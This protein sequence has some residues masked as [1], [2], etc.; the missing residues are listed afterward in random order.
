MKKRLKYCIP[1]MAAAMVMTAAAPGVM[2]AEDTHLNAAMFMWMDGLDPAK[3]WNGWTTMRCGIGET[4]LTANENM[5]VVPCLADSWEQVDDTTYKF[6]IRQGVKFSNGNDMT[7][8]TVKASIERTAEQNSRGSNLKLASIEV[9]GE[10]VIFKTTEPYSAFPYYLTEPMCIIVDTT[11]DTSNYDNQPVCTGAYA[12][13][14]YV[15][16]EKYEL[17]ANQYYWDG[18]PEVDSI[19]VLNID[20]DTKVSAIL[21]GDIKTAPTKTIPYFNF[22]VPTELTGVDTGI[23]DPRDTYADA[24]QWEEKAKD[25]AARFIKNFAKY[26]GNE[27][28]KA[29]VAA[30]PQL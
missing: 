15:P 29:L 21:S 16:E 23:L 18:V 3:D 2:A 13:E 27:A 12:C 20:D 26:E 25:L 22:E 24:A 5:E 4:L 14:E 19:T 30:G 28:G 11:V 1:A 17:V 6:H 10:N 9:D 7:P 8:E